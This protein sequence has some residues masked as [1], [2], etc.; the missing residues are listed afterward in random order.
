LSNSKSWKKIT[1]AIQQSPFTAQGD[2]GF[3]SFNNKHYGQFLCVINTY[4]K[5]VFA[6]PIAN[7]KAETLIAAIAQLKKVN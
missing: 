1:P 3:F 5:K 4:T 6:I 2:V 7:L